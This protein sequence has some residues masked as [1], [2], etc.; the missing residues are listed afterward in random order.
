VFAVVDQD[1]DWT[2]VIDTSYDVLFGASASEI[3][4]I[5]SSG[6]PPNWIGLTDTGELVPIEVGNED[7][8]RYGSDAPRTFW[9]AALDLAWSGDGRAEA[10]LRQAGFLR[11]Q[12][13]IKGYVSAVY[14]HDGT[15]ILESPTTVGTAG[16][17]AALTLLDPH[18]AGSMYAGQILGGVNRSGRL[19][20][21]GDPTDL[22]TQE[23]AW[24]TGAL[25]ARAMPNL[26]DSP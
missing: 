17:F 20:H 14:A 12:V 26:W 6:L 9:R 1:H 7:T 23:W 25:Y 5:R 8:T 19:V 21:W 2:G 18:A 3:T 22:Y 16:A 24:F 4:S 10:F 13:A 15:P 11:D